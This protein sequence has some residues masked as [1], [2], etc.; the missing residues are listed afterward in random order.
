MNALAAERPEEP[1]KQTRRIEVTDYRT[2]RVVAYAADRF[3]DDVRFERCGGR[4]HLVGA[5]RP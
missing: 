3:G 1:A 5:A 4:T 2:A